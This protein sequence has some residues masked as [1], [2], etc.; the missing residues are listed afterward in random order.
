MAIIAM[1]SIDGGGPIDPSDGI[2]GDWVSI[3]NTILI[4]AFVMIL[5]AFV[6]LCIWLDSYD[7]D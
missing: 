5:V 3:S 2:E 1:D 7:R 6:A 4:S